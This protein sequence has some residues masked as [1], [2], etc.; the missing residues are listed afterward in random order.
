MAR[1]EQKEPSMALGAGKY[2]DLCTHVREQS[3]ARVAI[4]I[5]VGGN[6]GSG[7]SCQGDD[8]TVLLKVPDMLEEMARLIRADNEGTH[9]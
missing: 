7:F 8:A 1:V 5:I 2:N 3:D 6:K 4:V 9:A